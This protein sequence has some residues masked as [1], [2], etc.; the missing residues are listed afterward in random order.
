VE[1]K[2]IQWKYL[3]HKIKYIFLRDSYAYPRWIF[4]LNSDQAQVNSVYGFL[5]PYGRGYGSLLGFP[6]FSVTETVRGCVSLKKYKFQ[7]CKQQGGKLSRLVYGFRLLY[8][9]SISMSIA[10]VACADKTFPTFGIMGVLDLLV[11][12]DA[13][14][15]HRI[16]VLIEL[17]VPNV[18]SL[19]T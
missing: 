2:S 12:V 9:Y 13:V 17:H 10:D 14:A 7:D 19:D 4:L 11:L 8:I 1:S 15:P 5:K 3:L 6:S 18:L 16:A